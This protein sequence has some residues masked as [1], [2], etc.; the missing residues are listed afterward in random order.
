[1]TSL[2]FFIMLSILLDATGAL[3]AWRAGRVAGQDLTESERAELHKHR[4]VLQ[5]FV[6]KFP[7]GNGSSREEAYLI[8]PHGGDGSK[9]DDA[10]KFAFAFGL[11]VDA[12]RQY[13]PVTAL[14]VAFKP[15][16]DRL[17][18]A[19]GGATTMTIYPIEEQ[20]VYDQIERHKRLCALA[21]WSEGVVSQDY[22]DINDKNWLAG[23]TPSTQGVRRNL[24][25]VLT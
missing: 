14:P 22:G 5:N 16:A 7:E 3:A 6:W 18:L 1:M 12:A 23:P 25:S 19:S 11:D 10:E 17:R 4:W 8:V 24:H 13:V 15:F 20:E 21:L 9:A 2:P